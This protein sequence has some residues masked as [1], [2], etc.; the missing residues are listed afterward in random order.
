M[1]IDHVNLVVAALD[2]TQAFYQNVFNLEVILE[3]RLNGSWIDEVM[4][5]QDVDARCIIL[6]DSERM[7]RIELLCFTH[8]P[9]LAGD[10]HRPPMAL[11]LR[12]FAVRVANL[13]ACLDRARQFPDVHVGPVVNVPTTILAS[14]KRMAYL[15]DPDGVIVELCQYGESR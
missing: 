13:D 9:T 8:P 6:A 10:S 15:R 5:L 2:R 3:A 4:E 12:H 11:G 14:G 1:Q 7:L